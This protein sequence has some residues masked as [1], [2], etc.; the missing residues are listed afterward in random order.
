MKNSAWDVLHRSA[1]TCASVAEL[2]SLLS[3]A[4]AS[5]N[6][7]RCT[8]HASE[9]FRTH[10]VKEGTPHAYFAYTVDFHNHVNRLTGKRELTYDEALSTTATSATPK[11]DILSQMITLFA[12]SRTRQVQPGPS[13][14]ATGAIQKKP[15]TKCNKNR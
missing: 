8:Q 6:C 14:R 5:E 9:Y 15:C 2:R 10:A 12:Q 13:G 11:R 7:D 1:L 3:Q 4:V